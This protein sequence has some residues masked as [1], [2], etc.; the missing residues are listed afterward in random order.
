[1]GGGRR[2]ARRLQPRLGARGAGRGGGQVEL[3]E[4]TPAEAPDWVRDVVAEHGG[5]FRDFAESSRSCVLR[6]AYYLGASF[7]TTYPVLRWELG[8]EERP[9]VRQPVVTGF[10]RGRGP[11]RAAGGRDA[12]GRRR[13]AG[14]GR[15]L[16]RGRHGL[17]MGQVRAVQ[18]VPGLAFEA[19]E[20]WYDPQRWPAWVDGFG[21]VVK[22]EGEWPAVGARVGVGLAPGG[23]GRVVER[24]TAYEARV[25]QTL[26]V[27]D[28]QAAGHPARA[29]TPGADR[30]RWRSSSS[31]SSRSARRSPRSPTRS[32][33]AARCATRSRRSLQRFARER[34]GDLELDC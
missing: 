6:A 31:T 1:M 32:S 10:A 16:A 34:Q 27:E 23:R 26:A 33:S 25:G 14:A 13:R 24:V 28:E 12:A 5:G 18:A 11:R 20:L 17:A 22:L 4:A 3:V 30:S 19:E 7:V 9:E 29:F 21:H 2:R 8:G 15:A